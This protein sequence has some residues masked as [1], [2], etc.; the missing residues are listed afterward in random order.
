MRIPSRDASGSAIVHCGS[1]VVDR[2][3]CSRSIGWRELQ[4]CD[5]RGSA[6]TTVSWV[7][8]RASVARASLL[9]RSCR[10]SPKGRPRP[11]LSPAT[12]NWLPMT[13]AL[14]SSMPPR[15]LR[16]NHDLDDQ[17]ITIFDVL[18]VADDLLAGAIVVF[19]EGRLV[20]RDSRSA[21]EQ[22]ATKIAHR[23][24]AVGAR[25]QSSAA[26]SRSVRLPIGCRDQA[27][28]SPPV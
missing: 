16:R 9:R 7:A 13:Y 4:G 17:F 21:D 25:S 20:S 23:T 15:L 2:D 28:P 24:R 10:S 27:R 14:R 22:R 6:S 12:R 26:P 3:L 18:D 19:V 5:S 8:C 1:C 11:A